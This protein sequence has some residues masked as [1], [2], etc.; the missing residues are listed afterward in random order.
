MPARARYR[1]E[2]SAFARVAIDQ[3]G[4]R[5][6]RARHQRDLAVTRD[7]GGIEHAHRGRV[8]CEHQPSR[9]TTAAAIVAVCVMVRLMFVTPRLAGSSAYFP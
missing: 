6:A 8:E 3:R 2:R 7:G 9:M 1:D 4:D 5:H